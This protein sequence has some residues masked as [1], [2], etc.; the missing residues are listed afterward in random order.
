MERDMSSQNTTLCRSGCGFYGSSAQ[1]GLC[2]KCYK[3]ALKRKQAA[4]T[5]SSSV[6]SSSI[7]GS[8]TSYNSS[9]ANSV[10]EPSSTSLPLLPPT[11]NE[12][13]LSTGTPTIPSAQFKIEV[14]FKY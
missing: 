13:I 9:V 8:S 4:P 6:A 5:S 11:L 7:T 10:V 12:S 14:S 2:S 3:D 1:D